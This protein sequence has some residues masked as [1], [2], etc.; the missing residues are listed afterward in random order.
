MPDAEKVTDTESVAKWTGTFPL[1]AE[2]ATIPVSVAV[3]AFKPHKRIRIQ[4]LTH[5]LSRLQVEQVQDEICAAL[6]ASVLSRQFSEEAHHEQG[7]PIGDA[8]PERAP[9]DRASG[10]PR[11]PS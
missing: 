11:P 2:H 10:L 5:G 4:V 6:G 7:A 3:F 9:L 8:R 1:K